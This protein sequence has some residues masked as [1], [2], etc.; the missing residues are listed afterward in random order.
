MKI[1][2]YISV[3]RHDCSIFN[4]LQVAMGDEPVEK[5]PFHFYRWHA[6][7]FTLFGFRLI[8]GKFR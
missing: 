1:L 8:V 3:L 7:W 6:H 2:N 4:M 5:C